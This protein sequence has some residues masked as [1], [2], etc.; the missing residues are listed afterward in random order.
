MLTP[1]DGS[2]A[3]SGGDKAGDASDIPKI[4]R[5]SF[6]NYISQYVSTDFTEKRMKLNSSCNSGKGGGAKPGRRTIYGSSP[7]Y[8]RGNFP[9]ASALGPV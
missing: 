7:V 8:A 6:I 2:P 4:K 1:A 3:E 9:H 5:L